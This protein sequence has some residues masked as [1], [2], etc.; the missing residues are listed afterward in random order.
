MFRFKQNTPHSHRPALSL[1]AGVL[2]VLLIGPGLVDKGL[3]QLN[4]DKPKAVKGIGIEEKLGDQ[5][6]SDIQLIDSKGDTLQMAELFSQDKPILFNPGYYECPQLCSLIRTGVFKAV[7]NLNWT[8]GTDYNIV[9]FS[10][11]SS[12]THHLADS[13]KKH[14]IS[15]FEREGAED[16]WYFLTGSQKQVRRLTEA[17]GFGFKYD[18]SKDQYAHRSAIIFSSP[19]GKITRY[20][21]G[22]QFKSQNVKNALYEAADGKIGNTVERIVLSCYQYSPQEDSYVPVAFRIMKLGG[23]ATAVILGGFL[24]IFWYRERVKKKNKS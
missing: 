24:S 3:A 15:R 14:Y 12:E 8:P 19:E 10:F 21:Y 2:A 11:D 7:D 6:P 16:G 13:V 5:I 4:D 18:A 20:L 9:S 1:I 23:I 17:V 22:I